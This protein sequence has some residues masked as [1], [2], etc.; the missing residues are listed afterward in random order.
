MNG[1]THYPGRALRAQSVDLGVI[2]S[3]RPATI[4]RPQTGAVPVA[5]TAP[6]GIAGSTRVTH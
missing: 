5:R 6:G 2:E 4:Q 1:D 3:L